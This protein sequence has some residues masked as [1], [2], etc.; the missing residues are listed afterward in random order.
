M[1]A[2]RPGFG[3]LLEQS[4]EVTPSASM[5]WTASGGTPSTCKARSGG[6]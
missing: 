1:A 2:E 4:D 5:R 3:K 6:C